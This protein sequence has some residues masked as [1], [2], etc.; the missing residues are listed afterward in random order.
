MVKRVLDSVVHEMSQTPTYN[1]F[2]VMD[3]NKEVVKQMMAYRDLW[4]QDGTINQNQGQT[5]HSFIK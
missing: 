4:A 5:Q 2:S 3:K 1:G